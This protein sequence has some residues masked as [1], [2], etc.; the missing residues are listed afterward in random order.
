MKNFILIMMVALVVTA[1]GKGNGRSDAYGNFEATEVMISA[2]AQGEILSL[3]LDEGSFID[4]GEVLGLIDTTELFLKKQQLVSSMAAVRTRLVTINAQAGV[5][6]QQKENLLV[7]KARLEKLFND[8]AAT[9]K[10]MDDI[11]GALD[12]LKAQIN[13]TNSQKQQVEAEMETMAVQIAQV[14][15]ALSKCLIRNPAAGTV[16]VKYAEAGEVAVPGKPL[17]K[18]ADLR[19]M[20]LKVYVSGDQLPHI[21]LGQEVEVQIDRTKKENQSMKGT[22]SW[23]SSTAEFTPKTIQTKDERVNLVYAVKVRVENDGSIKIGM[24]GEINF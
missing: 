21:K 9:R 13:A 23:I 4:S 14:E 7:D 17:Y 3:H 2:M 5:Q 24:P 20:K 18:I 8:G 1:C 19:T 11:Q 22:I 16:L 15:E 6:Q 10:Q 12:L